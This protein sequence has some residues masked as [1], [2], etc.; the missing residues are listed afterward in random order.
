MKRQ[1]ADCSKTFGYDSDKE[2]DVLVMWWARD[3]GD[4]KTEEGTKYGCDSS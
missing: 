2:G 4:D 3:S 1:G